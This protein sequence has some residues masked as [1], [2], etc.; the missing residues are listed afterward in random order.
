MNVFARKRLPSK[1]SKN[2]RFFHKFSKNVERYGGF[3]WFSENLPSC[4]Q[5]FSPKAHSLWEIGRY[6][7][8]AGIIYTSG[9]PS[10]PARHSGCCTRSRRGFP[11]RQA[12]WEPYFISPAVGGVNPPGGR[13]R[14][15]RTPERRTAPMPLRGSQ[16]PRRGNHLYFRLSITASSSQRLLY[17]F[18]AWPLTQW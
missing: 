1:H 15:R 11:I 7:I 18:S 13:V 8:A 12:G 6:S 9:S 3:C 2:R 10:P 5:D 4:S 16:G 14:L 17:S